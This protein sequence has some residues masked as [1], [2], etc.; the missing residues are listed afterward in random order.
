[1]SPRAQKIEVDHRVPLC[2][3]M[4]EDFGYREGLSIRADSA[5]EQPGLGKTFQASHSEALGQ[6]SDRLHMVQDG[7]KNKILLR[8]GT[9]IDGTGS[10]PTL[11]SVLVVGDLIAEVGQFSPPMDASIIDCTGMTISP[12]FIDAHSHSDLQVLES[13]KEKV[14]QGVTTEVVGNCGFSAYPIPTDRKLLYEFANGIFCGDNSWGWESAKDYL[15][16]VERLAKMANVVSL[17]GHGTLRVAQVGHKMGPLL[18]RDLDD[19]ESKL[20]EFLSMGA[21]GLSTGLMYAPGSSAPREELER[22]C[23]VVARH[24][25]IYATHM[26]SYSKDLLEAIDEQ[27]ELAKR[28]GC[29]LEISHLQ[30]AGRKTWTTQAIAIEKI[31]EARSSGIDVTFDCYPYTAGSTV[32]TQLLPQWVLDGGLDAVLARLSNK[33]EH[34]R[35]AGE[36]ASLSEQR[37]ADIYIASVASKSNS[38]LVGQTLA[39]IAEG[40]GCEAAE[41]VL[42]LLQEEHGA[43]QII[44]FNQS[45]ENLKQS[46][47]HPLSIVVSDG[48]YVKGR[49]HPRLYGTFPLL[50]GKICRERGWLTLTEAIYKITDFPARRFGISRRG[51]LQPGYFGDIT[52][53]DADTTDSHATYSNPA[54][55]PVGINCVLRNGKQ[56]VPFHG[57]SP[58]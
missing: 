16:S 12:G 38:A 34:T 5:L 47:T 18:P 29:K 45:E 49:P 37:W 51:R 52:I 1:M 39:S 8:N 35:I 53:F 20:D 32:L 30:A 48:F 58:A 17:V 41:V 43:V 23:S 31:E 3:H 44:S 42:S 10:P 57:S 40:R 19:M 9:V 26:R 22:L 55:S 33:S 24:G 50:L 2:Q 21:S 46:L 28:T 54:V 14:E 15:L 25:K 4:A 11:G 56:V 13:R 6:R 36:T 27:I 7:G